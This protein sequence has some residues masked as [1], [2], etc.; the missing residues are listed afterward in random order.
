MQDLRTKLED[1]VGN[2]MHHDNLLV[3][4]V[5]V[6]LLFLSLSIRSTQKSLKV[7]LGE[8]DANFTALCQ[9]GIKQGSEDFQRLREADKRYQAQLATV[10]N[11]AFEKASI[12]Q[13]AI[14]SSDGDLREVDLS[15]LD[16][17]LSMLSERAY[18]SSNPERPL[19]ASSTNR[20]NSV[21]KRLSKFRRSSS[22]GS[23]LNE[24][25]RSSK[26]K[27]RKQTDIGIGW[28]RLASSRTSASPRSPNTLRRPN[29]L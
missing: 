3:E 26:R 2:L 5:Q 25:W 11:N 22:A 6:R 20:N 16:N 1:L 23:A 13:N 27:P 4:Q 14:N 7:V 15:A 24:T 12:D 21:A 17:I 19:P 9:Q 10:T 28:L 8:F 18:R 29:V